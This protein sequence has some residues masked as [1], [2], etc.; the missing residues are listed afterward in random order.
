MAWLATD[1]DVLQLDAGIGHQ[2]EV[3]RLEPLADDLQA[4]ARQQVVHVGDAAGD[5]VLHRDHPERA[6]RPT[7]P[8]RR[9]PRTSAVRNR[10]IIWEGLTAGFVGVGARFALKGDGFAGHGCRFL[11]SSGGASGKVI[12]PKRTAPSLPETTPWPVRRR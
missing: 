12:E 10:L 3:D 2:L 7:S 11:P 5:G 6:G 4:R 8:P 1:L 9:R